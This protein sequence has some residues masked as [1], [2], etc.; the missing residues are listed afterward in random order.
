M[1]ANRSRRVASLLSSAALVFALVGVEAAP[2]LAA[3]VCY[4]NWQATGANLGIS[5]VDAYTHLQSAVN[6]PRCTE[7]W[8]A[9]GTYTPL[10]GVATP[11][12]PRV[13]Y[14]EIRSSGDIPMALYGGFGGTEILRSQRNPVSHPTILSG[15][16]GRPGD[17]T[18]NSI[19]VVVTIIDSTSSN[20]GSI[21]LDGFTV[22]GGYAFDTTSGAQSDGGGI[23]Q[24]L[25][26]EHPE[27]DTREHDYQGER[28]RDVERE[29]R[30]RHVCQQVQDHHL[31]DP[32][33]RKTSPTTAAACLSPA[34]RRATQSG[35]T[36]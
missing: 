11:S 10:G 33:S 4:V 18:D 29:S 28:H 16:I 2:A 27:R 19:H 9:Q 25:W 14:F 17:R 20:L 24:Q 30:R 23:L 32:C 12:D 8:V 35:W 1:S 21:L 6:E 15:N 34:Q 3:T 31:Q 13:V 26:R 22:S 7:I 36:R 5:W